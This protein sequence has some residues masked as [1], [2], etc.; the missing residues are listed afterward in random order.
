ML[1]FKGPEW[2]VSREGC[3]DVGRALASSGGGARMDGVACEPLVQ[4]LH[5]PR[6]SRP[7]DRPGQK[8]RYGST[9]AA[10]G[11]VAVCLPPSPSGGAERRTMPRAKGQ[12]HAASLV[13]MGDR[14]WEHPLR[15]GPLRSTPLWCT[16]GRPWLP[17]PRGLYA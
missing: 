12:S 8:T 4:A 1:M 2:P 7:D 15:G 11:A 13:G 3:A 10:L 14:P 6:A 5:P 17:R 16:V 9:D